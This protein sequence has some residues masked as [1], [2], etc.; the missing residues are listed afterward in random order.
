M[1]TPYWKGCVFLALTSG[2][3]SWKILERKSALR[4]RNVLTI[5]AS[6]GVRKRCDDNSS[7]NLLHSLNVKDI[8]HIITIS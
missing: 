3:L 5:T 4:L 2:Y 6:H 7:Q 1:R 8:S